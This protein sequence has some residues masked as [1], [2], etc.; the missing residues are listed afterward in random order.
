VFDG[1]ADVVILVF[2]AL[3]GKGKKGERKRG[4]KEGEEG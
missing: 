2:A 3:K 1:R 4:G